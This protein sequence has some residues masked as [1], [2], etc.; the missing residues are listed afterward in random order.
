MSPSRIVLPFALTVLSLPAFAGTSAPVGVASSVPAMPSVLPVAPAPQPISKA[1]DAVVAAVA[2]ISNGQAVIKQA[3]KAPLG[4]IGMA[5]NLGGDRN[6]IM[7]ASPDGKYMV[8]GG[9]FG[10]DGQNYTMAAAQKYLPPPPPAPNA[11]SN[12]AALKDAKTFVWGQASAKKQLWMLADP[13]CIFCHKMF[14]GLEPFV[15]NGTVKVHVILAGFLKPDSLGKAAAIFAS[16]DPGAALVLDETKFNAAAEEGGIKPDLTNKNAVAAVK[17]NNA[18]MQSHGIGGTP[19]ILYRNK[20]GQPAVMPGFTAD[21]KGLLDG[22]Q[23][24]AQP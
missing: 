15:Q 21:V 14:K 10:A 22:V 1:P 2:K 9:I 20:A 17:A 11:A 12:F 13:D 23:S 16:K 6:M 24:T 7:Y 19:Y 18:W 3:F 5:V 4:L 8:M